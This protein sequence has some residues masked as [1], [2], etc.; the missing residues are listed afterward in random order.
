MQDNGRNVRFLIQLA[1][2]HALVDCYAQ[3]VAPVWP[4]LRSNLALESWS[5]TLLIAAWQLATSVSQPV[6][7]YWGDRSG[8]RRMLVL[9]PALA[10]LCTSLIGFAGSAPTLGFLLVA[11]GLGVGAFHPVAAVAVVEAGKERP[12]RALAVF[13]F[14]G[15]LAP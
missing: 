13:A 8:G 11:G 12:A 2:L 15:M 6:F 3:L 14:G 10:I 7:G 1:V 4:Q 5:L 9:G